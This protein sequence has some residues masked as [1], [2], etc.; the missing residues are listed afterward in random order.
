MPTPDSMSKGRRLPPKGAAV[1]FRTPSIA[2]DPL[3]PH[4]VDDIAKDKDR[5][6]HHDDPAHPVRLT[7]DTEKLGRTK[8]LDEGL[9]HNVHPSGLQ[10]SVRLAIRTTPMVDNPLSPAT[11]FRGKSMV[12]AWKLPVNY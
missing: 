6:A 3:A 12:Y 4:H 1:F 8:T 2:A 7:L 11:V 5:A 10:S 9:P